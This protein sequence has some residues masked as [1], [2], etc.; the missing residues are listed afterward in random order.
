LSF[1]LDL[2]EEGVVYELLHRLPIVAKIEIRINERETH[3]EIIEKLIDFCLV[4]ASV[5]SLV[6][7][8]FIQTNIQIFEVVRVVVP[9]KSVVFRFQTH[10]FVDTIYPYCFLI[11]VEKVVLSAIINVNSS[12]FSLP[13]RLTFRV[14]I[15]VRI[16][17]I[18][19]LNSIIPDVGIKRLFNSEC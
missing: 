19:F 12:L 4:L 3:V 5:V 1:T 11:I 9:L 7:I 13:D 10:Q 6:S 16:I 2:K 8:A 17:L 14:S 15:I 18:N